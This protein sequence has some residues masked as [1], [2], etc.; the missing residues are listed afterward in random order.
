MTVIDTEAA[1]RAALP[2][3]FSQP[4][5]ERWMPVLQGRDRNPL[6]NQGRR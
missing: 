5:P 4:G 1:T 6:P 3:P 2:V